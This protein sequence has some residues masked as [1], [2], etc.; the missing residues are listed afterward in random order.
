MGNQLP[1]L[2]LMFLYKNRDWNAQ[3]FRKYENLT[4]LFLT[5]ALP[6]YW[7]VVW[8]KV[9]KELEL[10]RFYVNLTPHFHKV[11][12]GS[13]FHYDLSIHSLNSQCSLSAIAGDLYGKWS[14][15]TAWPHKSE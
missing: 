5:N 3:D 8:L 15:I 7:W 1:V 9:N 2:T 13:L 14:H 12:Q 11:I 10:D 6:Q 4:C